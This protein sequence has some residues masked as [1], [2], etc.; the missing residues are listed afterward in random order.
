MSISKAVTMVA[1][2]LIQFAVSIGVFLLV[3]LILFDGFQ[4]ASVKDFIRFIAI[5]MLIQVALMNL[6]IVFCNLVRNMAF[7]MAFGICVSAGLFSLITGLIDRF[8]LPFNTTD[9]LLSILMKQLPVSY[10]S[11]LYIRALIISVGSIMI[12][13]VTS[14]IIMKKQDIK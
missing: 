9:Y 10:D 12:Y 1:Y 14:L 13:Q 5:Q 6:C 2:S 8:N 7:S 11:T 3:Y 4:F